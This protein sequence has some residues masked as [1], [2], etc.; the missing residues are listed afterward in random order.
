MGGADVD[1]VGQGRLR[2]STPYPHALVREMQG[3]GAPPR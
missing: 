1:L 2:R 3:K